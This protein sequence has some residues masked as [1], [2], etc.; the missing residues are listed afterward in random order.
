MDVLVC[1]CPSSRV[2]TLLS[3][4]S[5]LNPVNHLV[6]LFMQYPITWEGLL[7]LLDDVQLN[8]IADQLEEAALTGV[9]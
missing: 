2:T 7:K 5:E 8:G 4:N 1:S 3:T 9:V 6:F